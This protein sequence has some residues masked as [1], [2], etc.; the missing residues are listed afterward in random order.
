[1]LVLLV[2]V[3]AGCEERGC[4]ITPE[5][6]C[7]TQL[8]EIDGAKSTWALE[9]KKTNTDTPSPTELY[10]STNYLR[11]TP[12]CPDGGIYKIGNVQTRPTCS[13]KGHTL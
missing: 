13:V 10:D 5:T 2:V 11:Y 7:R 6:V 8:K 9:N 12:V 3:L 1:M 4:R